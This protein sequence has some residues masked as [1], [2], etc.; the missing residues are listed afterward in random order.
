MVTSTCKKDDSFDV[1]CQMKNEGQDTY[2]VKTRHTYLLSLILLNRI[3]RNVFT[4]NNTLRT[5]TATGDGVDEEQ[6]LVA[7]Q[8][9]VKHILKASLNAF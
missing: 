9:I 4:T 5:V 2:T 7:F 8:L 6:I 3:P 1:T